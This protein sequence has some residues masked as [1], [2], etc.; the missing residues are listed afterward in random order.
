[1]AGGLPS[2][3]YAQQTLLAMGYAY[4]GPE[5][6]EVLDLRAQYLASIGAIGEALTAEEV[7]ELD[8]QEEQSP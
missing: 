6:I 5:I 3:E 7:A 4:D 1:M 2:A 8:A